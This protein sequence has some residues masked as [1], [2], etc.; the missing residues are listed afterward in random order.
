[1][2]LTGNRITIILKDHDLETLRILQAKLIKETKKNW[3]FS[4]VV[5]L[6]LSIGIGSKDYKDM[7]DTVIGVSKKEKKK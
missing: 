5:S 6:I 2:N 1:M 7:I 4:S 3:S